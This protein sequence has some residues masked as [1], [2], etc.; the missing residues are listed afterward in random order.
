MIKS[1]KSLKTTVVLLFVL[2]SFLNSQV[3]EDCLCYPPFTQ[4]KV[5]MAVDSCKYFETKDKVVDCKEIGFPIMLNT[6]SSYIYGKRNLFIS[7]DEYIFKE[8]Y[9]LTDTLKS[10][11]DIDSDFQH[12]IEFFT[13]MEESFGEI[14]FFASYCDNCYPLDALIQFDDYK[15]VSEVKYFMGD[16]TEY[17]KELMGLEYYI[18]V[19]A[20]N[21]STNNESDTDNS[22][23]MTYSS[24]KNEID[25]RAN[26]IRK[27]EIYNLLGQLVFSKADIL[28]KQTISI[29]N[30]IG[31]FII[32]AYDGSKIIYTEIVNDY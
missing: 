1:F 23:I 4:G 22:V 6:D 27:I 7:L 15:K 10:I 26:R 14:L 29:H 18:D 9:T 24:Q 25:I 19:F 17:Q 3:D 31:T 28:N 2:T 20:A 11:T 21:T 32:V 5:L 13:K 30:I 12:H 8:E 16:L